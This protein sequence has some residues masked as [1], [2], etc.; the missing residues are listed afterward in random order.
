M[1]A[2]EPLERKKGALKGAVF[3]NGLIGIT[4]AARVMAANGG[5]K[6]GDVSSVELNRP[7]KGFFHLCSTASLS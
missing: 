1:T 3:F 2:Q 5:K 7:K 4:G 6:T